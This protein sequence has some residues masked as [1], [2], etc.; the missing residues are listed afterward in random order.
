MPSID[1]LMIDQDPARSLREGRVAPNV[2]VMIG[3]VSNEYTMFV[4]LSMTEDDYKSLAVG[5]SGAPYFGP[6]NAAVILPRYPA[7]A[8][9]SPGLLFFSFLFFFNTCSPLSLIH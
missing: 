5:P 4:N 8:Y 9:D 2:D 1:G 7:S 3:D 6:D